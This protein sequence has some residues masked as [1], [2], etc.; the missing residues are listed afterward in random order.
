MEKAATWIHAIGGIHVNSSIWTKVEFSSSRETFWGMLKFLFGT[1]GP[2][3]TMLTFIWVLGHLLQA[4]C[5]EV[6]VCQ[7]F[8]DR[9][10]VF[11]K[12]LLIQGSFDSSFM[13]KRVNVSLSDRLRA[14]VVMACVVRWPAVFQG[15][16]LSSVDSIAILVGEVLDGFVCQSPFS[17]A[18]NALT[19]REINNFVVGSCY[20]VLW[21]LE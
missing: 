6:W 17:F 4:A 19:W 14:V 3:N 8:V 2:Q 21:T 20:L 10:Q 12:S 16:C 11:L 15:G 5:Q 18:S 7:S 13:L 9:H 1:A